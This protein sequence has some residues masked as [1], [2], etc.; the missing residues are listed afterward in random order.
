MAGEAE[1]D[2]AELAR[3]RRDLAAA[4]GRARL[5]LLLDAPDPGARVRSLPADELYF[6]VREVGL[7]DAG[8]LVRLASPGQFRT[9]LDLECWKKDRL[10]PARAL[11]W[12]AAARGRADR[13]E[14]AE[15]AWRR[16][17]EALDVELLE[18]VLLGV[19]R[20]HDLESW[21]DPPAHWLRTPDGQFAVEFLV[22]GAEHETAQHLLDDLV[23]ADPFQAARFL[24][25][26][27]WE[28]PSELEETALRWRAGRLQDLGHPPLE[29][30][31]SWFASPRPPAA[32]APP[33]RTPGLLRG[34]RRPG[35]YL[36]G[37]ADALP[38][39]AREA[40]DPQLAAAANAVLVADGVDVSD[41]EA[42]R[43]AARAARTLVELGLEAASGG[44]VLAAAAALASTPV[45]ALFQRGFGRLLELGRR[46][47]R[48]LST[49]PGWPPPIGEALRAL[50]GRRPR[51]FPGLEAPRAEWG[52]PAAAAH[53]PRPFGSLEE[54]ARAE[55]AVAE[56]EGPAPG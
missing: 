21:P 47:E 27:R 51:Y 25:A 15:R 34:P 24:S 16:K 12:L 18:L 46:A 37:A 29:E 23:A 49:G 1:A 36:E 40:L 52:S 3:L 11:P 50:C 4:R 54:V 44:D 31:L 17:L 26:L 22:E 13:E 41:P 30:A 55:A 35:S 19:F 9:F 28:L 43:A 45:K 56:A 8:D 7:A 32:P 14:A 5:D 53:E 20:V 38:P 6:A 42:V 48:L 2:R 10:E 33:D 39:G